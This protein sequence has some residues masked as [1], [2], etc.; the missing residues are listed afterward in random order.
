MLVNLGFLSV[1][2]RPTPSKSASDWFEQL[3]TNANANG[4]DSFDLRMSQLQISK[5]KLMDKGETVNIVEPF[6]ILGEVAVENKTFGGGMKIWCG[7]VL[8]QVALRADADVVNIVIKL[9][10][11]LMGG[12]STSTTTSTTSTTTATPKLKK[13]SQISQIPTLHTQ[14]KIQV[15]ERAKL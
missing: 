15:S 7:A 8:P 3:D 11:E 10:E 13:V 14:F 5:G 9:R 12:G 1:K 4:V 2:S 6:E